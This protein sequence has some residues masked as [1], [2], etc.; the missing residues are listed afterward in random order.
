MTWLSSLPHQ[1]P[2]RAA[3]ALIRKDDKSIEGKFLWTANESLPPQI[4]LIEAMAQFAGGLVFDAQ[5]FLSGID[6]CEIAQAIEPGDVVIVNVSI[7]ADFGRIFRFNGTASIDGV[8]VARGR[9]YLAAP[10]H[11]QT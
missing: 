8:E 10:S 5:G 3:S 4:M 1:I 7:E 11:A 6:N 2:F 9:F